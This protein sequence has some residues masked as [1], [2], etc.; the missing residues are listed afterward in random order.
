MICPI[1]LEPE[2]D[3]NYTLGADNTHQNMNK[4]MA[5]YALQ[6]FLINWGIIGYGTLHLKQKCFKVETAH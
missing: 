1:L 5:S 4:Y 2:G 6:I 3:N